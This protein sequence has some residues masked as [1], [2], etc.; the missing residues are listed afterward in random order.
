MSDWTWVFEP[1]ADNVVGDTP[2]GAR[3]GDSDRRVVEG[4]A[5]E[6]ADAAAVKYTG[7]IEYGTSGI[8]PVQTYARGPYL[9]WYLEDR[10]GD[11]E[12]IDDGPC[13]RILKVTLWPV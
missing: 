6:L 1:D 9:I 11:D 8:S 3:L 12:N 2:G 4:I 10:R 7:P 5:Q 13:V